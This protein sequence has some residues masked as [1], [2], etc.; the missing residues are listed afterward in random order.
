MK[1]QKYMKKEESERE[2]QADTWPMGTMMSR[3]MP[4]AWLKASIIAENPTSRL[5]RSM[6]LA[7]SSS[8]KRVDVG[9]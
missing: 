3:K 1:I 4:L 5:S 2:D 9:S 6:L 8:E 7:A